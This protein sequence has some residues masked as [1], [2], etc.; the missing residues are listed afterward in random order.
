MFSCLAWAY[1]INPSELPGGRTA[2][3]PGQ[4][5]GGFLDGQFSV[6]FAVCLW[7]GCLLYCIS[8]VGGSGRQH[9]G[10][11]DQDQVQD[12][13]VGRVSIADVHSFEP[14]HVDHLP[15]WVLGFHH[16]IEKINRLYTAV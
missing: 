8:S 16:P 10:H 13:Q 6:F 2:A 1:W 12:L 15:V 4:V 9:Q 11:Q 3:P 14:L 7:P 5:R